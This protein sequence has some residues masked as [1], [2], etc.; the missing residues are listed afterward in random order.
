MWSQ[1]MAYGFLEIW[2]RPFEKEKIL[3]YVCAENGTSGAGARFA[4]RQ[5]GRL[6]QDAARN[7]AGEG[8]AAEATQGSLQGK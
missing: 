4:A 1:K 8:A 7:A 3:T 6:Q 2:K 5:T